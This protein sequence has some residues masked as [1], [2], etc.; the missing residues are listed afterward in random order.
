MQPPS[1]CMRLACPMHPSLPSALRHGPIPGMR[2]IP[3]HPEQREGS[4]CEAFEAP[5]TLATAHA[6]LRTGILH[7]VQDDRE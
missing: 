1:F 7:V 5:A 2:L 3:W 6:S 4:L